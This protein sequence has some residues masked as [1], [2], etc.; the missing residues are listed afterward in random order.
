MEIVLSA[1]QSEKNKQNTSM[2][3][4]TKIHL[5]QQESGMWAMTHPY[6]SSSNCLM[7][8]ALQISVWAY[9]VK[10]MGS[11]FPNPP[12]QGLA[13]LIR[14]DRLLATFHL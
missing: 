7:E 10:K 2:R 12:K 9:V 4:Y 1:Y 8:A 5:E 13:H 3:K 6:L 14:R 11:V